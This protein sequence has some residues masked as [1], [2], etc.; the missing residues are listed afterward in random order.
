MQVYSAFYSVDLSLSKYATL[1]HTGRVDQLSTLPEGSNTFYYPSLSLSSVLSDYIQL[2]SFIS[3][4]KLR[5]SF[6]DVKGGLT[7]S[8]I[9]SA[10]TAIT[11]LS[12]NGGLLGY[13]S[14]L[15]S[16]YDGPSYTNQNAYSFQSYY[17]GTPSVGFSNTLANSTLKP[18]NR[19]SYEGGVDLKFLKNKQVSNFSILF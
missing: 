6:A 16:S 11:G 5:G 9:P 3:F 2:P 10:F 12:T 14:D 13:G 15:Y 1:S 18:F 17:N 4:A 8:T 7:Q 19:I